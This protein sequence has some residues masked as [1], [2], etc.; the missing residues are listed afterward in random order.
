METDDP[1]KGF[2][3]SS[4]LNMYYD[5]SSQI[6][7]DIVNQRCYYWDESTNQWQDYTYYYYQYYAS[8]FSK[9][10]SGTSQG[11]VDGDQQMYEEQEVNG[12]VE[13]SDVP[14]ELSKELQSL[15]EIQF[16][17]LSEHTTISIPPHPTTDESPSKLLVLDYE[18]HETP[19]STSDVN[20]SELIVIPEEEDQNNFNSTT[21]VDQYPGSNTS[22]YTTTST[23][24]TT[25]EYHQEEQ[26]TSKLSATLI[27]NSKTDITINPSSMK[28]VMGDMKEIDKLK[29]PTH[30][31]S[32]STRM[33]SISS[34][35]N[36]GSSSRV[37]SSR[38][39]SSSSDSFP[40]NSSIRIGRSKKNDIVLSHPLAS[41]Y[42][43]EIKWECIHFTNYYT[44]YD[45]G[46]THGTWLNSDKLTPTK[47]REKKFGVILQNDDVISIGELQQ[48]SKT[49][50][51]HE[52]GKEVEEEE[53]GQLPQDGDGYENENNKHVDPLPSGD[54]NQHDN[55]NNKQVCTFKIRIFDH[56]TH[57]II[58][59]SNTTTTTVATVNKAQKTGNNDNNIDN[60][61]DGV[62][63]VHLKFQHQYRHQQP[64]AK[65]AST[66]YYVDNKKHTRNRGEI[67]EKELGKSLQEHI[68]DIQNLVTSDVVS[69]DKKMGKA[70]PVAS[71]LQKPLP[72]TNKGFQ[73][74]LKMGWNQ[75][76]NDS[77]SRLIP[78]DPR[79]NKQGLG[80]R[81]HK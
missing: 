76:I 49:S 4:D 70:P 59:T 67:K 37:G 1:L 2:I 16:T 79:N 28:I 12:G 74:L 8:I 39:G 48:Q 15:V 47:K 69:T 52:K 3:Y 23:T 57:I 66:G 46:S 78:L 53:E 51:Q 58:P 33:N 77:N 42:H 30:Q 19:P 10:H 60:N 75:E 62:R 29:Q 40:L 22:M 18:T 65:F 31:Q 38:G 71:S 13:S 24:T 14:P 7:L 80:Y 11:Q 26:I 21:H 36:G 55:S 63:V 61:D 27:D 35:G 5:A 72:E 45:I 56:N 50:Q 64:K 32:I 54:N 20:P 34:G 81:H 9:V 41:K 73:L 25:S 68:D 6:Y 43:C 44:L 17:H